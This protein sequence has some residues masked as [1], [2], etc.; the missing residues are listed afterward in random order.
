MGPSGVMWGRRERWAVGV[1][2]LCAASDCAVIAWGRSGFARVRLAVGGA[3]RKRCS[4]VRRDEWRGRG[5]AGR[6]GR[7]ADGGGAAVRRGECACGCESVCKVRAAR[8]RVE[9]VYAAGRFNDPLCCRTNF[10]SNVAFTKTVAR[11]T[12]VCAIAPRADS[13][14]IRPRHAIKSLIPPR[15]KSQ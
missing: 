9:C 2:A 7:G 15:G 6:R 14:S 11:C 5:G 12:N 3:A 8:R 1:R 4:E 10:G 13:R